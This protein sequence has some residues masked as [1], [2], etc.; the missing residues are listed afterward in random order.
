MQEFRMEHQQSNQLEFEDVDGDVEKVVIEST[1][2]MKDTILDDSSLCQEEEIDKST[3]F[4]V[5]PPP[6][7][8]SR[9]LKAKL[10]VQ[11][12]YSRWRQKLA[13]EYEMEAK[14][15]E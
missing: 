6:L 8:H 2:D 1:E 4:K 14:P 9:N 11:S 7:E 10:G 5:V 3:L 15:L 13:K 12:I